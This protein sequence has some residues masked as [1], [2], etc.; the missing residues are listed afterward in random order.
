MTGG[1][2]LG[3]L[4]PGLPFLIITALPP[5][6]V[7]AQQGL[8]HLWM[9]RTIDLGHGW[10]FSIVDPAQYIWMLPTMAI[11]GLLLAVRSPAK[12][13]QAVLAAVLVTAM[14]CM[15]TPFLFDALSKVLPYWLV[16]RARYVAEVI[17]F[18]S[19]TGGFAWL[20]RAAL[21]SR[22]SRI[23]FALTVAC[24][25]LVA[26]RAGIKSQIEGYRPQLAW[27]QRAREL[28]ETVGPVVP[29]GALVAANPEWSLV[30]PAVHLSAVMAPEL[31]N[32][33]PADGALLQR[34]RDAQELLASATTLERRREILAQD[35]VDFVLIGDNPDRGVQDA[36]ASLGDLVADRHGF[37]V[38]K[39]RR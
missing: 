19:I 16:R 39:V 17:A 11:T 8:A 35:R 24:A 9:L 23:A 12:M 26:F 32:A 36:L 1:L 31:F 28:Q 27:L 25:S 29:A 15:F 34:Y 10:R 30:L 37:R 3:A 33:N 5:N 13:K 38:F 6:Y 18:A 7:D 22:A 21:R 4:L 14:V 2:I 20:S